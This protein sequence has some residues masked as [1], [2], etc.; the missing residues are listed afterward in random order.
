[1][2]ARPLLRSMNLWS[3]SRPFHRARSRPLC[4]LP[5][6]KKKIKELFTKPEFVLKLGAGFWLAVLNEQPRCQFGLDC[7]L[8][9]S[10]SGKN[11]D[12]LWLEFGL[13]GWLRSMQRFC[14]V[15]WLKNKNYSPCFV[16]CVTSECTSA[17]SVGIWTFESLEKTKKPPFWRG[18][19]KIVSFFFFA[20]LGLP[21]SHGALGVLSDEILFVKSFKSS[22]ELI[23]QL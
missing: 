4:P 9:E 10:T 13:M 22:R 14:M 12:G 5:A 1:M 11:D 18:T 19:E 16:S 8:R 15:F 2:T 17:I 23:D 6:K 3:R 20:S 21:L 7:R